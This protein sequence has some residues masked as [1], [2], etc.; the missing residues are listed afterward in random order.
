MPG[1]L[2][3]LLV[4]KRAPQSGQK[5]RSNRL[6]ESATYEYALVVPLS[7]VKSSLG[8]PNHVAASPPDAFL[9]SRQWQTAM[10]SGFRSNSNL[11]APQAHRP[12][13]FL[14]MSAVS[15]V[16]IPMHATH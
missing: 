5:F 13:N 14:L 4:Y 6:P 12:V 1:K 8:T 7:S 11:T 10:K 2:S 9:Q 16:A 3:R 15:F